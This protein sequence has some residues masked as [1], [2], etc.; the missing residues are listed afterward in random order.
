MRNW[1]LTFLLAFCAL[2]CSTAQV[3]LG[4]AINTDC[5]AHFANALV[6]TK[7]IQARSHIIMVADGTT[8]TT[9]DVMAT[10]QPSAG[11]QAT[12]HTKAVWILL[13]SFAIYCLM[14]LSYAIYKHLQSD[15]A[16]G[17]A[18]S[19][20]ARMEHWDVLKFLCIFFVVWGHF[21]EG[22]D[23][24]MTGSRVL[25][26]DGFAFV[27][28]VFGSSMNKNSILRMMCYT[29]GTNI[30]GGVLSGAAVMYCAS[31]NSGELD[32]IS[33][34]NVPEWGRLEWFERMRGYWYLWAI[35]T[36]RLTITPLF[37]YSTEWFSLPKVVPF[38]TVFVAVLAI[39]LALPYQ[40]FQREWYPLAFR[41]LY[42]APIFALG[43]LATPTEWNDLFGKS[44]SQ[45]IFLSFMVCVVLYYGP[46]TENVLADYITNNKSNRITWA[47]LYHDILHYA[48]K[49]CAVLAFACLTLPAVEFLSFLSPRTLAFI[50][51]SG[52]RTLYVYVLHIPLFVVAR[53]LG[54][55]KRVEPQVLWA[56]ALVTTFTFSS[57][58][59][60]LLFEWLVY[61]LW[62]LDL[63][64]WIAKRL[65]LPV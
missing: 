61:P 5:Q 25:K 63:F 46:G 60:E 31:L 4:V 28:G 34:W 50:T 64:N 54:I 13:V 33:F 57:S 14:C 22:E 11:S 47:G 43:L 59:T 17:A 9:T 30:L 48:I 7:A 56:P 42:L 36:W 26:M 35:L 58:L 45:I 52:A 15:V 29:L 53:G 41:I 19:G 38:I 24:G 65:Q 55:L 20:I 49:F 44:Y 16:E 8:L 12:Q 40:I 18:A 62:I 23:D 51:F 27:S 6:Q 39:P 3:D 2:C 21:L 1:Y 32:P 37:F 10:A